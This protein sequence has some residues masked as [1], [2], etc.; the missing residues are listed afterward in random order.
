[1]NCSVKILKAA[2]IAL[3][4]CCI[5]ACTKSEST[6]SSHSATETDESSSSDDDK[7]KQDSG[8]Q[9]T[10]LQPCTVV[11]TED[12]K[13]I[14]GIDF[15]ETTPQGNV[16]ALS[17]CDYFTSD[18]KQSMGI[19]IIRGSVAAKARIES[20]MRFPNHTSV[21]G[22]G[23]E[24]VWVPVTGSLDVRQGDDAIGIR[25]PQSMGDEATRLKYAKEIA[26]LVFD[27]I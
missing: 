25:I 27:R 24:A 10:A 20:A 17:N 13:Q 12:L 2:L 23:D 26:T 15:T 1:M 7:P 21:D 9:S 6:E 16:K 4:L 3:T 22:V 8:S 19:A 5:T 14:T 18:A 11:S